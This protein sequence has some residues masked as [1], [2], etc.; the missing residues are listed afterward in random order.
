MRPTHYRSAVTCLCIEPAVERFCR[1]PT[2]GLPSSSRARLSLP[3]CRSAHQLRL[4]E[5]VPVETSDLIA[6][7]ALVAALV[8]G[9]GAFVA[10]RR[11]GTRR[12]RLL[13]DYDATSL[14][15]ATAAASN[16]LQVTFQGVA[17]PQPHLVTVRLVN[18]GP[19]DIAS[20][21]FDNG[22]PLCID[23]GCMIYGIVK[24]SHPVR[25]VSG[26]VGSADPLQLAPGLLR[27][28]EEI[29]V[30]AVVSGVPQ[31]SLSSPL[32]DV[33]VI[34]GE[35]FDWRKDLAR[36]VWESFVLALPM[37]RVTLALSDAVIDGAL[38]PRPRH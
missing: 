20:S 22:A 1:R 17:V 36:T 2:G 4:V 33:D 16:L 35:A 21:H 31:P 19:R 26:P 15:P 29:V 27:R 7:I 9:V 5:Y 6:L 10:A 3:R 18:V 23:L 30:E 8:I 37:G 32:I 24:T 11:W 28:R 12:G 14:V 38:R 34:D 25:T 13:F